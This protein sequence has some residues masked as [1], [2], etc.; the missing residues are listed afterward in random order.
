MLLLHSFWNNRCSSRCLTRSFI[1]EQEINFDNFEVVEKSDHQGV[2]II[3][4]KIIE[5]SQQAFGNE[6]MLVSAV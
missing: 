2:C 4:E 5:H 1:R 3:E 6:N